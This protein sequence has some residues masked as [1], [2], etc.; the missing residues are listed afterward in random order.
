MPLSIAKVGRMTKQ[1]G[2]VVQSAWKKA[3]YLDKYNQW[4]TGYPWIPAHSLLNVAGRL[5]LT[6]I[7]QGHLLP[8]TVMF[9]VWLFGQMPIRVWTFVNEKFLVMRDDFHRQRM[10]VERNMGHGM[11][12]YIKRLIQQEEE[13]NKQQKPSV[14]ETALSPRLTDPAELD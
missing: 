1:A 14:A 8:A 11:E 6:S 12:N 7:V 10:G 13:A 3:T 2:M 5:G 4:F 9:K